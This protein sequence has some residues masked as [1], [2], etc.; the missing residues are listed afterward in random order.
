MPTRI[1]RPVINSFDSAIGV[2]FTCCFCDIITWIRQ[3]TAINQPM[4]KWKTPVI[5]VP[6][7]RKTVKPTS[8]VFTVV[9]PVTETSGQRDI[10]FYIWWYSVFLT[11][12]VVATGTWV[13]LHLKG[14]ATYSKASVLI[15]HGM[16]SLFCRYPL[17]CVQWLCTF[18]Y[19]R[20][21]RCMKYSF[22]F[23]ITVLLFSVVELENHSISSHNS[24]KRTLQNASALSGAAAK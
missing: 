23:T 14:I 12:A 2:A 11:V 19:F 6:T 9:L 20:Q 3:R 17:L 21:R 15:S 8:T 5:L 13:Y 18:T 16:F 7:D 10:T 22:Y 1:T 4:I 24:W